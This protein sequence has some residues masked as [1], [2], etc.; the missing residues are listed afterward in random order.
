ME[1]APGCAVTGGEGKLMREVWRRRGGG[2]SRGRE[3][4]CE[5]AG[6]ENRCWHSSAACWLPSPPSS[7]PLPFSVSLSL[8]H[9]LLIPHIIFAHYLT[10]QRDRRV[11]VSLVFCCSLSSWHSYSIFVSQWFLLTV[12]LWPR[13]SLFTSPISFGNYHR[14]SVCACVHVCVRPALCQLLIV[15][16]L[17]AGVDHHER[18][19]PPAR[20]WVSAPV[21]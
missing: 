11:E 17:A 13:S 12:G 15:L 9:L 18:G 5:E 6:L 1:K 10:T 4:S 16:G 2:S 20:V 8:P 21:Q 7:Q 14:N 3:G 19:S